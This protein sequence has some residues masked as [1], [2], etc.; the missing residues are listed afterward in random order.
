MPERV[1]CIFIESVPV[2]AA[3]AV[4]LQ[5]AFRAHLES[6]LLIMMSVPLPRRKGTGAAGTG[7]EE[8]LPLPTQD[9]REITLLG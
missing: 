5:R 9:R 3:P 8:K 2:I 7:G 6:A 4:S 1:A